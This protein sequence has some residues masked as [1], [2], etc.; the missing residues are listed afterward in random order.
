MIGAFVRFPVL[1]VCVWPIEVAEGVV[2]MQNIRAMT[3]S[4]QVRGK[5]GAIG[6]LDGRLF[7]GSFGREG[8]K[9]GKGCP[10]PTS[11]WQRRNTN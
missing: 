7:T 9:G 2:S 10:L 11:T 6:R 3:T 5:L 8:G 4:E 1:P